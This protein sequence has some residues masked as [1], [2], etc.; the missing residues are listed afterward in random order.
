MVKGPD[1]A[2]TIGTEHKDKNSKDALCWNCNA[3]LIYRN[4]AKKVRCYNC[5][6]VNDMDLNNGEGREFVKCP[7]KCCNIDLLVP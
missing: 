2:L 5:K 1:G 4:G 6:E 3:H 7:N